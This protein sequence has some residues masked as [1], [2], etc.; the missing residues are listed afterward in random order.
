MI[1]KELKRDQCNIKDTTKLINFSVVEELVHF[2]LQ[3]FNRYI[4]ND[5]LFCI[6]FKNL[7]LLIKSVNYQI[8]NFKTGCPNVFMVLKYYHYF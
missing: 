2:A 8:K 1:Q 4:N 5:I 3:V 7:S 6:V